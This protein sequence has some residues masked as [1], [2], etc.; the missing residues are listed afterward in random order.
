MA[1]P[2]SGTLT[3]N[4]IRTELGLTTPPYSLR[5][6]SSTAGFST[7]DA[8]SEFYGYSAGSSGYSYSTTTIA[9]PSTS[10]YTSY[11]GYWENSFSPY[12][13]DMTL[14]TYVSG[15]Y[16]FTPLGTTFYINGSGSSSITISSN[17]YI[18]L[19]TEAYNIPAYDYW[20]TP[21]TDAIG[22]LWDDLVIDE[23]SSIGTVT[24]G[25]WYTSGSD[26]N[27]NYFKLIVHCE[28]YGSGDEASWMLNWYR[29]S[30]Y[31]Y[32]V[33]R[34][35]V[36]PSGNTNGDGYVLTGPYLASPPTASTT[37]KVFRSSLTGTNWT[38]LGTG[39]II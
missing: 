37:S 4:D 14:G 30:S 23:G 17:G 20:Y 29:D 15:N 11:S 12:D 27:G 19:G 2:T 21:Q 8:I 6:M 39:S 36:T 13:D 33:T 3:M 22:G 38:Y 26:S 25:V 28:Q 5:S 18:A 24:Q 9:F 1:L 10:G 7:P 31:Q 32:I 34:T 16:T 35:R